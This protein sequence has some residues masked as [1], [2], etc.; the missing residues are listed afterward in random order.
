MKPT[1]HFLN[2]DFLQEHQIL[3]W[4]YTEDSL[5]LSY[6]QFNHWLQNKNE[7]ILNYLRGERALK[8]KD[9]KSYFPQFQSAL[10]FA[11]SYLEAKKFL[12]EQP[13]PLK[14]ASYTMG[15]QDQD[16]HLVVRKY[17]EVIARK[18][19]EEIPGLVCKLSLDTQPIL[20]RDL[21]HRAGL[22]WFG[23]NSMLILREHGSF[24][25]IGSLLLDQKL[26]LKTKPL[27]T[28]HCGQCRACIDVCPTNAIQESTRTLIADLCISTFTIEEFKE[29]DPPV[30]FDKAQGEIFGCDLCQDVC[31]WNKKVLPEIPL[32]L[33][34]QESEIYQFFNRPIDDVIFEL[35]GTSNREF[36][37]V[38]EDT[39]LAR[40]GRVG[41]LKNLKAFLKSKISV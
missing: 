21:A 10:V 9:L 14:L 33:A 40:T 20:E 36:K 1:L 5:A 32:E 11:F 24:F 38:F 19:E 6:P 16:Y 15:F 35:E 37:R 29:K 2:E 3:D 25:I 22:G 39:P 27:E 18:L 8:R 26:G 28:D 7:G 13:I 30:G 41:L 12:Q 17:L 34:F 23:K 31:P 4:G